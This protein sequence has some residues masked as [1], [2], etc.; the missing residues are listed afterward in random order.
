MGSSRFGGKPL[1]LIA[2]QPM[3]LR[4]LERAKLANC[5][6]RIICATDHV[7]I[8]EVC[9]S[10]GF[11][12]VLTPNCFTGSDRVAFVA[13]LL[14]LGLVVNLQGD[15]PVVSLELLQKVAESI[16]RDSQSWVTA[17][18]PLQN[19]DFS[20]PNVVKIRVLEGIAKEFTRN[21][22]HGPNWFAH[23]GIYAYSLERLN[24]FAALPPSAEER[25]QSLE[26]LRIFSRTPIRAVFTPEA[27]M[28]VDQ[29]SDIVAVEEYLSRSQI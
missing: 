19:A 5:F 13:S 11:E 9:K 12:A 26:Q 4:T 21:T 6:D 8:A 29:P 18:S 2:G 1:A 15:E 10:A 27:S 24:E 7:Q 23:R 3:I 28:S 16:S 14:H 17:M 25:E 20:N 22:V